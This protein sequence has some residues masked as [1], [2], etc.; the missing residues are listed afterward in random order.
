MEKTRK[1]NKAEAINELWR[2]GILHWKLDSGQKK[3]YKTYTDSTYKRIVFNASRRIGKSHTLLIIA[4]EKAIQHPGAQIKYGSGEATA[5]KKAIEPNIREILKD[6][7]KDM[8]PKYNRQESHY[9]FPNGSKLFIDG[10]DAGRA[11]RLRGAAAHLV[12]IDEAGFVNDDLHYIINSILQPQTMTTKGK[13][14]IASTPPLSSGHPYIDYMKDALYHGSYCKIT[15]PDYLEAVKLDPPH[16]KNRIPS[17]EVEDIKKMTDEIS[18]RREYLCEL[19]TSENDAIFPE[20]TEN[21]QR[22]CILDVIQKPSH[23]H[24]YT[25]IDFGFRDNH[26]I[27]FAFYDFKNNKIIIEDE[28]LIKGQETN[29][30]K[31]AQMIKEKED[32]LWYN[33]V[34]A[35]SI[36]VYLRVADDNMIVIKDLEELHNLSCVPTKKDDKQAAINDVRIKIASKQIVIN[37]RCKNLIFQ[38]KSGVWD[39]N[40]KSFGRSPD[41]GHYDLLDALIYLI[42]NIQWGTNP[43]PNGSKFNLDTHFRKDIKEELPESSRVFKEIFIKNPFRRK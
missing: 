24:P 9:A 13:I 11:E 7:P 2:R 16:F 31:L 35:V 20:F 8:M 41:A 1:P 27:L 5:I 12:I 42:R 22:E 3:L 39:K 17:D 23:Y 36:P 43:F 33:K 18:W 40:K 4:F 30:S 10:L 29:T 25:S 19:I 28:I 6:C 34:D 37:P 32:V 14:V 38:I 15:L 21:I 26:A